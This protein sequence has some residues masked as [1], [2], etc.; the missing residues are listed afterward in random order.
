MADEQTST[1]G[2][3]PR[4]AQA[5]V[6]LRL[7][8]ASYDEIATTLGY[9]SAGRAIAAVEGELAESVRAEDRER[10]REISGRRYERLIRSVW[11]K[12][13]TENPEHLVAVRTAADLITRYNNLWGLNAPTEFHVSSPT[14]AELER[15]VAQMTAAQAPKVIEYDVLQGLNEIEDTG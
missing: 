6:A 1:H 7:A 4:K 11:T 10:Q 3:A 2:Q 8:G 5:A 15:W 14:T 12:A 9:Q 13:T